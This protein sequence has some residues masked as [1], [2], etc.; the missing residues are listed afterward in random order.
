MDEHQPAQEVQEP[1]R[2][3]PLTGQTSLFED[4]P[5]APQKP[6]ETAENRHTIIVNTDVDPKLDPNSPEFDFDLW[7]AAITTTDENGLTGLDR[8][9][10]RMQSTM[11]RLTD[12][13]VTPV[14]TTALEEAVSTSLQNTIFGVFDTVNTIV[15]SDLF[16][17]IRDGL[18]AANTFLEEHREEI[19]ATAEVLQDLQPLIPFLQLELEEM[20]N[21]PQFKDCTIKDLLKNGFDENGNTIESPFKQAIERAKIRKAAFDEVEATA[22]AAEQLAEQLQP[23]QSLVPQK[24]TMPNNALMNALQ[25][26]PAINAGA[27]DLTVSNE[28]GRRKEITAYTMVSYEPAGTDITITDTKLSEYERQVSDAVVSLWI[29]AQRQGAQAAFTTD[30]IYRA[31]PGG[32][33]KASPQQRGAITKAM[34]KFR[35]L[36]IT[37]DATE[38]MRRRGIIGSNEVFTMDDYY[39]S[40]KRAQRKTKTGGKTVNAYLLNSE[41]MILTYCNMTNQLLTVDAKYIEVRKVKNGKP[42]TELVSMTAGRQAMTGYMLR[43]IAVMKRDK[44]NKIQQQSNVILFDTLF[45]ETGTATTDRK[46][47]GL[48]RNFCYDVLDYWKATGYIKDY[49]QQTKGRSI[50]GI[51]ICL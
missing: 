49:K 40:V 47:T 20:K 5:A 10:E 51:E 26:K 21:D 19:Q 14:D 32:G 34:E 23:L 45:S 17:S 37:I 30:T 25:Q 3:Q 38:E 29:E 8:A 11:Q 24:H 50:T 22:E 39:L 16:Q 48:N 2:E 9:R 15:N 1:I 35:Q 13:L 41:P 18:I 33:D 4:E 6:A 27:F 12:L 42:D 28:R 7:K 43:R 36:K 44:K 31:M 46:Q